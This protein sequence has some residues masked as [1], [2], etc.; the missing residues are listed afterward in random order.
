M[1]VFQ[2]SLDIYLLQNLPSEEATGVICKFID[3]VLCKNE[4]L[5]E[6]HQSRQYKNY[7]FN[8]LYP[9]SPDKIYHKDKRYHLLIR[10][11]DMNLAEHF[12]NEAVGVED[13]IL[14]VVDTQVKL[15]PKK[16]IDRLY[17]ITPCIL[18]TDYGYWKDHMSVEEFCR[19]IQN[20]LVKK[21]KDFT[22]QDIKE[23]FQLVRE[24]VFVNRKPILCKYK[25]VNLLGDKLD[26]YI[27]ENPM[28]QE[29]AYMAMGTGVLEANS[30]G[31][32][33]VNDKWKKQGVKAGAF[34][35]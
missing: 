4:N 18:K 10:T 34:L 3:K 20:N 9:V 22:R 16:P 30:R 32:G 2:I 28:A 6:F 14:K 29:L 33:F 5:I 12:A 26:L 1:I 15:L 21:Y 8:S 23:D 27:E 17:S 25:D 11:I 19:S 35:W 13:R 7:C 31:F 24:V